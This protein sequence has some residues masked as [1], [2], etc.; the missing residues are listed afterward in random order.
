M[1]LPNS[2]LL[3][4]NDI[5]GEFGGVLPYGLQDYYGAASGIPTSGLLGIQDFYGASASVSSMT[6]AVYERQDAETFTF[7]AGIQQGDLLF[8]TDFSAAS[9]G[10]APALVTPAGFSLISTYD[11][12]SSPGTIVRR[13]SSIFFKVATG[14]ESGST[15]SLSAKSQFGFGR[16]FVLRPNTP[17]IQSVTAANLYAFATD[18]NPGSRVISSA[19]SGGA[20]TVSF[21]VTWSGVDNTFTNL[22]N[23][24]ASFVVP[25]S[26]TAITYIAINNGPPPQN[27]TVTAG[28]S[29]FG[30]M[31]HCGYLQVS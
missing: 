20:V 5:A 26:S 3:G 29:G 28:N 19:S 23:A 10:G 12:S 22:A 11:L 6:V 24:D 4:L 21:A 9:S 30:N 17:N 7:P 2:G 25:D 31:I 18:G 13:R 15:V 14:T 8:F 27:Y 1:A 16:V